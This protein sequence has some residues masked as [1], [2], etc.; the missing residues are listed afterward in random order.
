M[1]ARRLRHIGAEIEQTGEQ[2]NPLPIEKE[3]PFGYGHPT[4]DAQNTNTLSANMKFHV[5]T[6]HHCPWCGF[7]DRYGWGEALFGECKPIA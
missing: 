4:N 2:E 6:L 7:L 3:M 1:T 5:S